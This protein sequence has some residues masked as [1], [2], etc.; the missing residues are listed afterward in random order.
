MMLMFGRG[1]VAGCLIA[2]VCSV[3]LATS[4][5]PIVPGYEQLQHAPKPPD[6]VSSGQLLLG[7]LNCSACH[8]TDSLHIDR[9][10]APDL[11]TTGSRITSQYLRAFLADPHAVKP[12]T[13]MPDLL[14][15]LD[16]PT[17]Q[18]DVESLTQ[19]LVSLGGPVIPSPAPATRERWKPGESCF[20]PSGVSRATHRRIRRTRK[21]HRFHCRTWR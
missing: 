4:A 19:F 16:D 5:P 9:K 8:Q 7:E 3:A 1:V 15:D 14:R 11:G 6:A 12:G 13:T 21:S 18:Q 2:S 10:G 20:T 17:R